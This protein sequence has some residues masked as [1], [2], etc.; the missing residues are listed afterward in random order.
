[1]IINFIIRT[2][3]DMIGTDQLQTITQKIYFNE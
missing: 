3:I 2:Q 1:M